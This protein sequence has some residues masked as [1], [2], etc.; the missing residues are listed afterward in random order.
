M[1]SMGSSCHGAS[2]ERTCSASL[3]ISS[4]AVS[5]DFVWIGF[6]GHDSTGNLLA[7]V[8]AKDKSISVP[9]VATCAE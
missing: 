7:V 6:P 1:K 8:P 9:G 3:C 5:G 2:R 4:V